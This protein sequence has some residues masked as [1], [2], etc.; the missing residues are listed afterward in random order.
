M[1]LFNVPI[2]WDK[3]REEPENPCFFVFLNVEQLHAKISALFCTTYTFFFL[4]T[5]FIKLTAFSK[6]KFLR[7]E[8]QLLPLNT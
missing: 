8:K 1:C 2:F 7:L 4:S 6:L 3:R 5:V